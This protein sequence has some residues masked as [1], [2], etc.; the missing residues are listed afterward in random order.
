M[1]TH[2]VNTLSIL[3]FL[4]LIACE[5]ENTSDTPADPPV[6]AQFSTSAS[7]ITVGE[8]VTFTDASTGEPTSRKWTFEGGEPATSTDPNTEVMY[9]VAGSFRVTLQV[10][11]GD[12]Q[13]TETLE[14][15]IVVEAE[16]VPLEAAFSAD[17]TKIQVGGTITFA[18]VSTGNPDA[19][20]WVFE[21][22]EPA[23]STDQ[24]PQVTYAT[25]G[26]YDVKLVIRRG[27]EMVEVTKTDYITVQNDVTATARCLPTTF[28]AY[29]EEGKKFFGLTFRYENDK[30]VEFGDI[31]F[32]E[33]GNEDTTRI[34]AY[35][36]NE[37]GYIASYVRGNTGCYMYTYNYDEDGYLI[38]E[39][40]TT[41]RGVGQGGCGD[42]QWNTIRYSDIN[43]YG[44][45][46]EILEFDNGDDG[47]TSELTRQDQFQY[48]NLTD[49]EILSRGNDSEIPQAYEDYIYNDKKHYF[50]GLNELH[51]WGKGNII[52]FGNLIASHPVALEHNITQ[53]IRYSEG[54]LDVDNVTYLTYEAYN[55]SGYPT[56]FFVE[57]SES[58]V[59]ER[60]FSARITVEYSC[61][62]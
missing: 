33:E 57:G 37:D 20:E 19:W 24:N 6:I 1:K 21:G 48:Q 10:F 27:D 9:P 61:Q 29:D 35:E 2:V 42:Q 31:S 50:S 30:L 18:D 13:D 44:Y 5:E 28:I 58:V 62:P 16:A 11:R 55:G 17:T 8:S 60:T 22:G 3:C 41:T 46:F 45:P 40:Q 32:D 26:T 38:D 25:A 56:E 7:T 4:T 23:T 59:G 51:L 49:V 15:A 14:N 52:V 36:Y 43:E 12:T 47:T 34:I 54:A 53:L 39:V